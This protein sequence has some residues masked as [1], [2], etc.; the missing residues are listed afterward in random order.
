MFGHFLWG[1]WML[2]LL[3]IQGFQHGGALFGVHGEGWVPVIGRTGKLSSTPSPM[4]N[5]YGKKYAV[6]LAYVF[7]RQGMSII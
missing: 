1:G 7:G 3:H 4:K 5:P 2:Q 6:V